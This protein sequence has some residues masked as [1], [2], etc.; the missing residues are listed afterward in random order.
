MA[1]GFK[2]SSRFGV[3]GVLV[4]MA[5]VAFI[6]LTMGSGEDANPVVQASGSQR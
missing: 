3:I 1:G 2:R 5:A 4:A 6:G